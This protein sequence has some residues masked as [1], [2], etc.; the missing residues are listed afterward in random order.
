MRREFAARGLV[1]RL[2]S[3]VAEFLGLL[4]RG[5]A[6]LSYLTIEVG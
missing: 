6:L 3:R 2:V 4:D 5:H 1:P